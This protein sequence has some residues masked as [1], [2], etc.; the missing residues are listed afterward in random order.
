MAEPASKS[1]APA[2]KPTKAEAAKAKQEEERVAKD[3]ALIAHFNELVPAGRS[4]WL[5]L[6]AYLTFIFVTVLAVEDIDFFLPQRSTALPLVNVTIPTRSFFIFAPILGAALY[7]YLHFNIR[8]VVEVFLALPPEHKGQRIETFLKPWILVDHLQ[9]VSHGGPGRRMDGPAG[10]TTILMVWLAGPLVLS[11][12]WIRS[13]PAHSEWI[14]GVIGLSLAGCIYAGLS[15]WMLFRKVKGKAGDLIN[16][17]A[18]SGAV[19]AVLLLVGFVRTDWGG[20]MALRHGSAQIETLL[21]RT[22]LRKAVLTTQDASTWQDREL[23][24]RQLL[25]DACKRAGVPDRLCAVGIEDSDDPR[26]AAIERG[27]EDWCLEEMGLGPVECEEFSDR[28]RFDAISEWPRRTRTLYAGSPALDLS[29]VDL[30]QADISEATIRNVDFTGANLAGANFD[31]AVLEGVIFDGADLTNAT[32]RGA[33]ISDARFYNSVLTQTDFSRSRLRS[34]TFWSDIAS[35]DQGTNFN[36]SNMRGVYFMLISL[37][38]ASFIGADIGAALLF[39]ATLQNA[40]FQDLRF[41]NSMVSGSDM[42]GANWSGA[43]LRRSFLS[44][45]V[46]D[47]DEFNEDQLEDIV[48]FNSARLEDA[49]ENRPGPRGSGDDLGEMIELEEAEESE[50][51]EMTLQARFDLLSCWPRVPFEIKLI[52]WWLSQAPDNDPDAYDLSVAAV[53][54]PR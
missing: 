38:Q 1:T 21:A 16:V 12:F 22:D 26:V 42:T 14:T 24:G 43:W 7:I 3:E 17:V 41:K 37:E 23:L 39:G 46:L 5:A 31:G 45:A 19:A 34:S 51:D 49:Y 8:Q 10:F 6:L 48:V 35:G 53:T 47:A 32:F 11:Y 4:N 30:R 44:E 50:T 13:W 29:R 54:C 25:Q 52:F 28:L 2:K 20:S 18:V 36:A 27:M 15:T 9:R 33:D 40:N